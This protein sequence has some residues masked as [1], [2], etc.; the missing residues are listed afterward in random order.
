[1]ARTASHRSV[2]L[3]TAAGL[4]AALMYLFD[5]QHGRR[6]TAL[7][8][9]QWT[10][11]VRKGRTRSDAGWR[12][13][14]NRAGGLVARVRGAFDL[15][16]PD[17]DVLVE[18]V[19]AELGR[20][21]SH[22]HAIEVSAVDCWVTL[23]GP[24]LEREV[25][26]LLHAVQAVRGV[27]RVKNEL[28]PHADADVPALQGG[29]RTRPRSEFKQANWAPGPRLA[30]LGAGTA[31]ALY[32]AGRRG[33]P[34]ALLALVGT[35]LA[36]RAATNKDFGRL[37]GMSGDPHGVEIEK[38]I[39]IAAPREQVFELW[40]QCERFPQF[41]SLVEEVRQLDDDHWHWVVK[42][43]AGKRLEWDAAVTERRTPERI[44]W[45][46]EPDA[47]VQHVGCVRFD[48][49]GKGTR[50]TVRMSYNPPAGVIGHTV[51]ALFGR[52]AKRELD[53][54]LMRMKAFVETGRAPH[55]AAQARRSETPQAEPV[56]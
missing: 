37:L 11:L 29:R 13:L 12:D 21:V 42:G 52:D 45:R 17:D 15:E 19:R 46:S 32:G 5:P 33:V 26:P 28:V 39:H 20:W 47:P 3:L 36:V 9:D 4:G 24:I 43:P 48:E 30:V 10:R 56:R 14:V 40:S 55:D 53:A 27:R 35:G 34:G 22:P 2:N 6:R 23:A 8:R 18:R 16:T 51:A 38:A 25:Q 1:M 54:D 7:V 31:L 50:V 44:A 41:M 49:V